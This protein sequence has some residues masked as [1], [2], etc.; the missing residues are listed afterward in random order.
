MRE[1]VTGVNERGL[2]D[3]VL[4]AAGEGFNQF[5]LFRGKMS[6][7]HSERSNCATCD[8]PTSLGWRTNEHNNR[9]YNNGNHSRMLSAQVTY[10]SIYLT[11]ALNQITFS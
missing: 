3:A 9:I 4:R 2:S 8:L 1:D 7:K 11:Y 10:C 5:V 6:H